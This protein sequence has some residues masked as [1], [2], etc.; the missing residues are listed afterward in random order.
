MT[1]SKTDIKNQQSYTLRQSLRIKRRHLTRMKQHQHAQKITQRI[2]HSTLYKRSRHIALYLS[3]DGEVDL[4]FL[5][6]KLHSSSGSGHTKKC[7]LPVIISRQHGI[8]HFAPYETHTRLKKN[9]FGIL[10]PVYQ[11]KQLKTALQMDLVLAPLVA[12]DEQGNRMGMGGGFYDRALQHLKSNPIKTRSL[13]P[14]F[15]GIAHELQ[16]VRELESH[17]WDIALNA[18]V[19]ERRLSYFHQ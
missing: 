14:R 18:I 5:I 7:Y 13:K 1:P 19:T 2:V 15:V 3:A 10:E 4:S 11:K 8:I 16:R 9:C 6:N 12:F 17:T